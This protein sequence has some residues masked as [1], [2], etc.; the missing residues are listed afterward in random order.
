[1]EFPLVRENPM[2]TRLS[3]DPKCASNSIALN[4]QGSR[5]VRPMLSLKFY[6]ACREYD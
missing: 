5:R 6:T 3:L 2:P 1:M 4:R